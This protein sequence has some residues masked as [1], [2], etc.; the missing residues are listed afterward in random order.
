MSKSFSIETV[1][2]IILFDLLLQAHT[3]E[4]LGKLHQLYISKIKK[5]TKEVSILNV[6]FRLIL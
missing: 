4:S 6:P 1:S 3:Q 5:Q 2:K